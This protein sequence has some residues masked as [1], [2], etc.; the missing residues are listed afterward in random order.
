M[1]DVRACFNEASTRL[2]LKRRFVL[3]IISSSE[4]V[5]RGREG[6][7]A[8]DKTLNLFFDRIANSHKIKICIF[9]V[10]DVFDIR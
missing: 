6:R 7:G 1:S 8:E 3:V 5:R 4:E 9:Q 2:Q 10:F